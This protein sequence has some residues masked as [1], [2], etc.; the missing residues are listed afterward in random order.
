MKNTRLRVGLLLACSCGAFAQTDMR[1]HWMGTIETQGGARIG[2][3]IDLDK[4]AS[5]W[6]GTISIPLQN[7]SGLPLDA[8]SFAG[9]KGTFRI[10]GAPGD[11]TF[12]GTLS[13][14]GQTMDGTF[15]QGPL[16]SPLKLN[17]M[18]D[19]KV[20]VPKAS[21]VVAAQFVGRWEGSVD[22]GQTLH[23]VVTISNGS[24]G[25]HA[26]MTSPDQ[27]NTQIPVAAVSQ[28]GTK[29]MLDVK[30]IGGGYLGDLNSQGDEIRGTWTQVGNSIPLVL[31]KA[32]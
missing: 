1:G 25:A 13:A 27:G 7:A 26:V 17:R 20:E 14:D 22:V 4:N 21:P 32:K 11:P 10:K 30:A 5:G 24:D 2:L 9:G 19:A 8:V 28:Q 31:K 6:I 18:G 23:I 3:E 15:M 12:T 16:S 29:L